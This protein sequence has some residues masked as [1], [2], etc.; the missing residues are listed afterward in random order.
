MY[1]TYIRKQWK[2]WNKKIRKQ[3]T[4]T[5]RDNMKDVESEKNKKRYTVQHIREKGK[6]WKRY[7]INEIGATPMHPIKARLV[8]FGYETHNAYPTIKQ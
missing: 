2:R 4:V 5:Q 1:G 7:D 8:L 3:N 6:N